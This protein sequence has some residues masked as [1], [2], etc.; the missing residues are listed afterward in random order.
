MGIPKRQNKAVT[1]QA[2]P[3]YKIGEVAE[4]LGVTPRTLRFYE[5][6]EMLA[7]FRTAKGTRLYTEDDISRLRIIQHLAHL[8]APLHVIHELAVARPE[9]LSG[10]EASHKVYTLLNDL[11]VDVEKKKREFDEAQQQIA[12]ALK[13]VKKCFGCQEKPTF[14]DCKGCPVEKKTKKSRMF[15]LIWD[16]ARE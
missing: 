11:R 10:D 9:S 12:A 6:Q 7:P 8:G 15:H 1:A 14:N 16:Q 2:G 4:L 5:E 3:I 13:L